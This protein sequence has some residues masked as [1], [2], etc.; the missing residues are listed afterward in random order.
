M[1]E[2]SDIN[3]FYG[4]LQVIWDASCRIEKG[5][6][7]AII[8]PNGAGKTTI[9]KTIS[10]LLRPSSGEITFF[11]RRIN[12]LL[13]H[14]IVELGISHVP[15]GRHLFPHMTVLE[16]LEMGAYISRARNE[17]TDSLERVYQ[18]FPVLKER[19]NQLAGTLSGGE[20][21][22]LAIG[23]G[24]M[25][26]PSFLMLD[27]PS[28][29]LA[30]MLVSKT[31]DIVKRINEEGTTILLVEQ[32][33]N[34]ALELA[35]RAYLLETGKIVLEGEGTSLLDNSYIKTAYLGLRNGR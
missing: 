14:Q 34:Y 20:Q 19:K 25:S 2:L 27:E 35:H 3:V 13:P 15:E 24:L 8:G 7:V 6:I 28:L 32:N 21:Q 29:G 33:V 4:D 9:M 30:P 5:E 22:M 12:E 17:K 10:G 18:L 23:R 11:E 16:N 31:F 1:L 26:N